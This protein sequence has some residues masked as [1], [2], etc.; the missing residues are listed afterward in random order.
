[1][2]AIYDNVR[3]WANERGIISNGT[4]EGQGLKLVEEFGELAAG[5]A[6]NDREAIKDAIGDCIVVFTIIAAMQSNYDFHCLPCKGEIVPIHRL[7]GVALS[8]L[9]W[10]I[11][12]QNPNVLTVT[13]YNVRYVTQYFDAIASINLLTIDECLEH[14]WNQIK[15]RKGHMNAQGV[16]VKE[17]V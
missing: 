15:D 9:G 1:M 5:I 10:V 3:Q 11:G 17:E 2:K 7:H 8:N 4:I 6:R 12:G 14:A 16:F 13:G